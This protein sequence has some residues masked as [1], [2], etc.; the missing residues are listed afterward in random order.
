MSRP[1]ISFRYL[2]TIIFYIGCIVSPAA[3]LMSK[4][5]NSKCVVFQLRRRTL[6]FITKSIGKQHYRTSLCEPQIPLR[7]LGP[8][9]RV[10]WSTGFG[11]IDFIWRVHFEPLLRHIRNL[12]QRGIEVALRR[13]TP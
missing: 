10:R 5:E 9:Q 4:V 1:S 12:H 2:N 11:M 3:R 8:I 13:T 6:H 7:Q